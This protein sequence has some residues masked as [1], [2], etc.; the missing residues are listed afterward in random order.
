MMKKGKLNDLTFSHTIIIHHQLETS[1][2]KNKSPF[3]SHEMIHNYNHP[4][5]DAIRL[6]RSMCSTTQNMP[7]T[8]I[9]ATQSQ[10][11]GIQPVPSPGSKC[12]KSVR[13]RFGANTEKPSVSVP[14]THNSND[15]R[16]TTGTYILTQ[17]V[18]PEAKLHTR[19]GKNRAS[20]ILPSNPKS[21]PF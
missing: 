2:L 19:R 6:L 3:T 5:C 4:N 1:F 20:C 8:Q 18:H 21:R 9:W 7:I 14:D 15:N 10:G 16:R 13:T 11:K 12:L 17:E